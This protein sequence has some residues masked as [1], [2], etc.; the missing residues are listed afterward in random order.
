TAEAFI[1]QHYL[2]NSN[3]SIYWD[4][5]LCFLDSNV[6]DAG[7]FIRAYKQNW[8]YYQKRKLEGAHKHYQTPK[9]ISITGVPKNISQA[10]FVGNL[11]LEIQNDSS[12]GIQDTALI[13]ADE[14]LLN[15]MLQ[16]V[17]SSISQVNITMGMPLNKTV[18]YSFF[19]SFLDL[20]STSPDSGWFFEDVLSLFSNPICRSL[21]SSETMDMVVLISKDIKQ[22]NRLYLNHQYFE[23]YLAQSELITLLFPATAPTPLDWIDRSLQLIQKLK[24]IGQQQKNTMELEYLYQ[25][26]TLFN[27]LKRQI[28]PANF[29]TQLKSIKSLFKQLAALE[30][31][32]FIGEPLSGLQIMGMLE[33]RNLDF[34]TVIITS[35]NEG[36]LPAGKSTNS[37]FP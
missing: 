19:V 35:V 3:N 13:L 1:I 16:A 10:Q 14:S 30:T 8:P 25:F 15:P 26:H 4:I 32:S 21:S 24:V 33:S 36:I 34:E 22:H 11:L 12:N 37:F 17:P 29:V 27:Q 5:D 6:H 23:R 7:L 20:Q 31:T 28:E 9:K 2:E 18:L